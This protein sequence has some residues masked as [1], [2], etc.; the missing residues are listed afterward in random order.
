MVTKTKRKRIV[1]IDDHRLLRQGLE[2]LLNSTDEFV[3][4][5]EAG[6]AKEGL[7]VVRETKPDAV[8]VD[9]GLPDKDGLELTREM[10]EELPNLPVIVLSMHEEEHFAERARQAGA[11]AYVVKHEAIEKLESALRDAI[12]GYPTFPAGMKQSDNGKVS[13]KSPKKRA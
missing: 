7:A 12:K 10:K 8:I 9:V 2:R 5:G 4:C 6:A 13:P 3:V 11:M 1:I